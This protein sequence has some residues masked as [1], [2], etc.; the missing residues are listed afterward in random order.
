MTMMGDYIALDKQPQLLSKGS[1]K[2][3]ADL[4]FIQNVRKTSSAEPI[5][6][7]AAY[8]TKRDMVLRKIRQR[9]VVANH[10][11]LGAP[12]Q[13]VPSYKVETERQADSSPK[14]DKWR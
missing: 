7:A 12:L 4:D 11:A 6:T 10:E 5:S 2:D 14:T 13:V 9:G 1:S 3:L 8:F